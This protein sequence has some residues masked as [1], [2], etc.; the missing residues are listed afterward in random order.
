MKT[1]NLIKI[2][3]L[4]HQLH[5]IT[6]K[7][8]QLLQEYGADPTNAKLFLIIVRRREI[9]LISDGNKLIEVRVFYMKNNKFWRLYEKIYFLKN[10]TMNES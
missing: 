4:G 8:I 1:K 10:D 2:I 5:H 9:Q 7:K 3:G 6:P